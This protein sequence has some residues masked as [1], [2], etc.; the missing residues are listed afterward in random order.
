MRRLF[1]VV[2]EHDHGLSGNFAPGYFD[3]ARSTDRRF[4]APHAQKA[5]LDFFFHD[6]WEKMCKVRKSTSDVG[7]DLGTLFLPDFLMPFL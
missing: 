6:L 1:A 3:R 4:L 2:A 5:R 7:D